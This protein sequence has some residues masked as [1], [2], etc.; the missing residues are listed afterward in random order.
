MVEGTIADTSVRC[1]GFSGQCT[2]ACQR[3]TTGPM[4][5]NKVGGG[6][7]GQSLDYWVRIR[8]GYCND[9]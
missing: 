9:V 1:V 5:M 3:R 8:S 2:M 4:L 7:I 6:K